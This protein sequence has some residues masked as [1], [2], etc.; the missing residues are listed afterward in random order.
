[1]DKAEAVHY[2]KLSA[3]QGNADAQ[4]RYGLQLAK[5]EGVGRDRMQAA[6]YYKLAADQKHAYARLE[7][8]R[9]AR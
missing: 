6:H 5:G 9:R 7:L 8:S 2:L 1:M 4:F 3:D